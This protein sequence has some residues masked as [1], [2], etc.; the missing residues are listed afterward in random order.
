MKTEVK[1]DIKPSAY[2]R[3][4]LRER[5]GYVLSA[6]VDRITQVDAELVRLGVEPPREAGPPE[7]TRQAPPP[8]KATPPRPGR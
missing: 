5:E 4:L 3:A 7:T 6:K 1:A 2:A 8:E